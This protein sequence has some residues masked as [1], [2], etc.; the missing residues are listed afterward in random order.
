[1][2]AGVTATVRELFRL[3]ERQ[4][5]RYAVMR[6]YEH[7]P[8]IRDERLNRTTDIDLVI[9]SDDLPRWRQL[10]KGLAEHHG[11]DALAE[12]GH[13]TQSSVR[14]HHI[15]AYRFYRCSPPEFL[16][17]DVFH[18]YIAMGLPLMDE[19][20]ML[21]G[22]VHDEARGLTHID[23]RKETLYRLLQVHGLR[24]GGSSQEKVERYIGKIMAVYHSHDR[25]F[26]RLVGRYFG[27]FGKAA[28]GALPARNYARFSTC[29]RWAKLYFA[30]RFALGHPIQAAR[31]LMA[32]A[33][34]SRKRFVTR[35][36]G[37]VVK[38]CAASE[39]QRAVV[40]SVLD[41]LAQWNFVEE[42]SE[43]AVAGTAITPREHRVMEQ[44]GLVVEW[45]EAREAQV[46]IGQAGRSGTASLEA[47][48]RAL[49]ELLIERH[50]VLYREC[51]SRVAQ[52]S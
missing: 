17:V 44:G 35:Q 34:E 7:L 30:A 15:E 32:R 46:H 12:C 4:R 18:A 31:C 29:M 23:P 24:A 26:R 16:Q 47:V 42:W 39:E 3:L 20:E 14:D 52:V 25:D 33:R 28:V 10:V 50:P 43:R 11:W 40:R 2:V 21:D 48:R 27:I 41:G 38:I 49:I 45:V 9:H 6:N 19:A 13:W 1:M 37:F 8:N 5:I 22:R 51:G 36:C